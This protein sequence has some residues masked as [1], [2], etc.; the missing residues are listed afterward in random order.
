MSSRLDRTYDVIVVGGGLAGCTAAAVLARQGAAVL[1]LEKDRFPRDKL[2][3]EFLSTEVSELCDRL[4][5]LPVLVSSGARSIRRLQLT[6]PSGRTFETPL[7]GTAMGL[8][9]RTLDA[10]F[11]EHAREQGAEVREHCAVRSIDGSLSDGFIVEHDR[12]TERARVVV[13]AYGRREMLDRRLQRSFL[14]ETSPY[15]AFKAHFVGIDLGDCIELHGFPGGYCGLLMEEHGMVNVCWITHRN[16]LSRS[17]GSPESMMD[18]AFG[19]NP[20]LRRRLAGLERTSEFHAAAQLFFRKKGLFD[21][22]LCMVGDAAGMIAPLCGDGMGMAIASGE[23]AAHAIVPFLAGRIDAS[24]FRGSY[25]RGWSDRF[26]RRMQIGRMLHRALVRRG[27][28]EL[29]VRLARLFPSAA[30]SIIRATRQ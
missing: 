10:A 13:G 28:S 24:E 14:R 7:P 4:G 23:W 8:S 22:D 29:A 2:C 20:V 3:G 15:V 17:G 18:G 6:A 11:F 19:S 30:L 12:G 27:P 1:V 9:R 5:I 26:S 25:E 16:A 21:G